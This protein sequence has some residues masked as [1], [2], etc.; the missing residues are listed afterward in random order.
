M[1]GRVGAGT[2]KIMNIKVFRMGLS[3]VENASDLLGE[4]F[5]L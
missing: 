5:Y 4:M 2:P 1:M 3:L